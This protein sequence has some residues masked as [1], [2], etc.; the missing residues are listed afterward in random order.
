V[1]VVLGLFLA[2]TPAGAQTRSEA[3]CTLEK[4]V[5]TCDWQAFVQRLNE[6]QT[7]AVETDN[8][9]RF[10]ARQ[11]R[12]LAGALG[13]TVAPEN[14]LGDLTFLLIPMQSTGVHIGPA[15]EPLATLRIYA[16][17]PGNP[18]AMLLW[19]ETYAGQPD[20]PWPMTVHALIE[21]FQDRAQRH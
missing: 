5:Y 14:Q 18:R 9:D 7:V 11:L 15:G 3:G 2:S 12:E 13:K 1:L 17:A 8:M 4:Q 10:T 19:A 21:Q 16:T 6:A 20:R